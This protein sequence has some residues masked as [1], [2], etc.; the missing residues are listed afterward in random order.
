MIIVTETSSINC[1]VTMI[2][3][4]IHL[5]KFQEDN[6][7]SNYLPNVWRFENSTPDIIYLLLL[8][9]LPHF[10]CLQ[11]VLFGNHEQL[12]L[13]QTWLVWQK[14]APVGPSSPLY[15]AGIWQVILPEHRIETTGAINYRVLNR[16]M[17]VNSGNKILRFLGLHSF[18]RVSSFRQVQKN[19]PT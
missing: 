13:F 8:Q 11:H 16:I 15:L 12:P 1:K 5:P 14:P 2:K 7:I 19:L 18:L 9:L 4:R 3:L 17:S 10:S 6:K